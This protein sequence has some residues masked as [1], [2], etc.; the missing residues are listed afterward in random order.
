MIKKINLFV[1][2]I[3]SFMLISC[4]GSNDTTKP[5][6]TTE[7]TYSETM[8]KYHNAE[9]TITSVVNIDNN[10]SVKAKKKLNNHSSFIHNY[11]ETTD[12]DENLTG[13]FIYGET[14][15]N[16]AFIKM[17]IEPLSE[18]F[19]TLESLIQKGYSSLDIFNKYCFEEGK[20]NPI[21]ITTFD[22]NKDLLMI[23][24]WNN[25]HMVMS[26]EEGN[27][28]CMS[29]Y[30]YDD[31]VHINYDTPT[32]S[33]TYWQSS[34]KWYEE[35]D[36]LINS[37][38]FG[39]YGFSNEPLKII[40]DTYIVDGEILPVAVYYDENNPNHLV[41]PSLDG[42]YLSK[43]RIAQK[44]MTIYYDYQC[45]NSAPVFNFN[46]ENGV[47]LG[48]DYDGQLGFLSLPDGINSISLL[49]N[50]TI[51]SKVEAIEIPNTCENISLD[52]LNTIS[53]FIFVRGENKLDSLEKQIADQN[54]NIKVLYA[55]EYMDCYGILVPSDPHQPTEE[56]VVETPNEEVI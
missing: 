19:G 36:D 47:L 24:Y 8:I 21:R 15:F 38:V 52:A 4:G 50:Q 53:E 55:S 20:T 10:S 2:L 1:G 32:K 22:D 51:Y 28:Y 13:N 42:G 30:L 12:V 49:T 6:N 11:N 54:L 56:A 31:M 40:K 39:Y 44:F 26:G 3:T 46:I 5:D 41:L 43:D 48:S 9:E 23:D 7:L 33:L 34:K 35:I 18:A 14:D 16:E 17:T 25:Y 37:P 27:K 45:L 29:F